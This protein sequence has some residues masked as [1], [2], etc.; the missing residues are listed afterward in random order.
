MNCGGLGQPLQDRARRRKVFSPGALDRGAMPPELVALV[1][2]PLSL[3]AV[4]FVGAMI[5][6]CIEKGDLLRDTGRQRPIV[7]ILPCDIAA[8]RQ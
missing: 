7:M 3:I 4:L 6:I 1:D 8:A 2:H 5:G